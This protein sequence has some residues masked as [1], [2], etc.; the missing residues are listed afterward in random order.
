MNWVL[1]KRNKIDQKMDHGR[2]D[3]IKKKRQKETQVEKKSIHEEVDICK[4]WH[5][6]KYFMVSK[7][8]IEEQLTWDLH[9]LNDVVLIQ[10]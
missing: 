7:T 2:C 6:Y 10:Q 5:V 9:V 4:I 1:K 8:K 3:Q